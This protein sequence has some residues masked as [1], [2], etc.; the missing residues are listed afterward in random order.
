MR[1]AELEVQLSRAAG[2]TMKMPVSQTMRKQLQLRKMKAEGPQRA[3]REASSSLCCCG[4]PVWT[5]V[6]ENVIQIAIPTWSR[7]VTD[8]VVR[9]WIRTAADLRR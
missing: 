9:S 6:K 4:V 1:L 5:L 2:R 7:M 3:S 8:E